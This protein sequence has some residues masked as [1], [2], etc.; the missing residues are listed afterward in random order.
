MKTLGGLGACSHTRPDTLPSRR[1]SFISR[2]L[3]GAKEEE[4][5]FCDIVSHLGEQYHPLSLRRVCPRGPKRNVG[6]SRAPATP[7]LSPAR[8]MGFGVQSHLSVWWVSHL[9]VPVP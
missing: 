4:G 1:P 3:Q 9:G 7:G 2:A 6:G 5:A 8:L